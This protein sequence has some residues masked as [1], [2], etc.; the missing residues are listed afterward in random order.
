MEND[1]NACHSIWLALAD[2]KFR[3]RVDLDS[4][5]EEL[6]PSCSVHAALIQHLQEFQQKDGSTSINI[7]PRSKYTSA[8][9]GGGYPGS[10]LLLVYRPSV[11]NHPGTGR[12]LDPDWVDIELARKWKH[13]CLTVHGTICENPFKIWPTRPAWLIDVEQNCIVAG[14]KIDRPFAAL[15]YR[16]G[17]HP[18]CTIDADTWSK[19]QEPNAPQMEP[20]L[21]PMIKHAMYITSAIGERYLWADVLCIPHHDRDAATLQLQLMGAIYGNALVT[22]IAMD[23]D[24]QEGIPGLRGISS[25]RKINQKVVPFGKE[26]IVMR[27]TYGQ[28]MNP[29]IPYSHRGWTYQEYMYSRRRLLF[30]QKELHWECSCST[31]H[32]EM[33]F[34]AEVDKYIDD[35]KRIIR[36]GFPDLRYMS[37][38]ISDYNKRQLRYDEDALPAI[39]GLLSVASRSFTDGFLY[40]LPEMF[41]DCALGWRPAFLKYVEDRWRNLRRRTPSQ[42]PI[43]GQLHPS[44]L[45]SWSWIGW[46]GHVD[47]DET[48]RVLA[49]QVG[50]YKETFPITEWYTAESPTASASERRHIRSTWFTDRESYKDPNTPLPPGWTRHERSTQLKKICV[51]PDGCGEFIFKHEAIPAQEWYYPFPVPTISESTPPCMFEQTAYLFCET[52]RTQL[53]ARREGF[54]LSSNTVRLL[55]DDNVK[56]GSLYCHNKLQ[57]EGILYAAE[58]SERQGEVPLGKQVDLIAVSRYKEYT[59]RYGTRVWGDE[60]PQATSEN[61]VVLWVE[62]VDGVAYRLASGEVEKEAW[63]KLALENIS[64]ILG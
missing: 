40:G 52:Q 36:Y 51:Y 24:S 49:D 11:P 22:I 43:D 6:S 62:W 54:G 39:S 61:I 60:I 18:S 32:E 12:I 28:L 57:L 58:D 3:Q 15:S 31:W 13:Q 14:Q 21:S 48:A 30:N 10:C 26:Q 41:F 17:D 29:D 55:D 50:I 45:P 33:I 9:M 53:W 4:L 1:C 35:T 46:Q 27:N 56:V 47:L 2:T 19:L 20:Y 8:R 5:A 23:T 25:S 64:L 7:R 44:Q 34:G 63:D 59:R 16:F 42:R 38:I 37:G